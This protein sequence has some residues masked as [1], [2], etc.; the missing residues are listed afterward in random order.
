MIR[1][2]IVEHDQSVADSLV[3]LLEEHDFA[4]VAVASA[5][6]ALEAPV[7]DVVLAGLKLPGISGVEL[8]R[9]LKQRDAS[10]P[11][12]LLTG[13]GT[14]RDAVEA[15]RAGALDFITE[16][17]E[18]TVIVERLRK[19]A[20]RRQIERE[21]DR[22]RGAA[23][24][25]AESESMSAVLEQVSRIAVREVPVLL[26]GESGCGKE[27]VATFLHEHS[28]R[29]QGPLVRVH[30]GAVS[31]TLF[32]AEFFGTVRGAGASSDRA[33]WFA[34]ADGGTLFLDEI[35]TLPLDGQE[36]LLRAIETGEVRPVGATFK[37]IVDVRVVAVCRCEP[38]RSRR[39][40]RG[41]ARDH[42]PVVPTSRTSRWT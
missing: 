17:I 30:C 7:C 41:R 9:K 4:A 21:R 6:E 39:A 20:E 11:V 23:G 10:Q 26:T 8:L 19:A 27:V 35:G 14:A 1:V 42:R 32:E 25:V 34:E 15:M 12:L 3:A 38:A 31:P 29:R 28:A 2:L 22:L 18:P 37:R 16:P 5:E 24:I 40:H 33:G 36:T 13:V